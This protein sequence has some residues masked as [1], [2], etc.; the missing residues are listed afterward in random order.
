[1][2]WTKD[3]LSITFQNKIAFHLLVPMKEMSKKM[4]LVLEFSQFL[5]IFNSIWLHQLFKEFREKQF[6]SPVKMIF[7][8]QILGTKAYLQLLNWK[9]LHI[10]I[11]WSTIPIWIFNSVRLSKN[12]NLFFWTK[13]LRENPKMCSI[14]PILKKP[15]L[16]KLNGVIS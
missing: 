16:S 15:H 3:L 12:L 2:N 4:S 7:K 1:M 11:V 14:L 9:S 8:Y 6:F 13:I 10:E 5:I